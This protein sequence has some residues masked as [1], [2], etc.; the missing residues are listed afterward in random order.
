[1]NNEILNQSQKIFDTFEKWDAF[2]Q[3][4]ISNINK[5]W[6]SLVYNQITQNG[7]L[8]SEKYSSDWEARCNG[9]EIYWTLRDCGPS[10]LGVA[11]GLDKARFGLLVNA[12]RYDSKKIQ[13]ILST[14]EFR[15]LRNL[16]RAPVNC[17]WW[18]L[19]EDYNFS[20]SNCKYNGK[21]EPYQLIWYAI[22]NFNELCD[23]ITSKLEHIFAHADLIRRIN[24]ETKNN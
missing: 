4:K 2:E 17:G 3:L 6:E 12:D 9:N 8:I 5:Y 16:I 21:M 10:S 22:N 7:S 23:Q 24:N 20:F 13:A 18:I 1:M 14:Y 11:L 19:F 15:S